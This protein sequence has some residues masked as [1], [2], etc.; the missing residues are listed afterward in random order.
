MVPGLGDVEATDKEAEAWLFGELP[1]SARELLSADYY[2]DWIRSG[3]K[4]PA[5]D[6]C[7]G[8]RVPLL[9]GGED[10]V[11]NLGIVPLRVYL[12]LCG[13]LAAPA[14]PEGPVSSIR[15]DSDG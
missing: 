15:L 5:A 12:S 14:T 1:A 2:E 11:P 4:R 7:V 3:G 8:Y 9:L 13:Q 10:D 6:E